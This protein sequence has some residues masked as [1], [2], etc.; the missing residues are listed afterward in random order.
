MRRCC[1]SSIA[2]SGID[3]RLASYLRAYQA[4][5]DRLRPPTADMVR[6]LLSYLHTRPITVTGER[7]LV[8][9]PTASKKKSNAPRA[10]ALREHE[11]HFYIV[12]DLLAAPGTINLRVIADDYYAIVP[13]GTDPTSS[14]LRRAYLQYVI[15][16][17]MLRFNKEIAARREPLR[18]LL[19][20]RETGR[21]ERH[22]RCLYRRFAIA[23]G[24]R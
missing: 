20:E 22:A 17:L 14:E 23:G 3:E 15:D 16:P 7:V 8:R 5:G 1:A 24:C 9:A 19:K 12:P 11:R 4:E 10:Y 2:K 6:S 18:Q 21:R 13:E